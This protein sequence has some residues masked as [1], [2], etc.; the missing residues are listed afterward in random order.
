MHTNELPLRHLL[1]HLDGK[2]TGPKGYWG[3]IGKNLENCEKR[4]IIQFRKIDVSFPEIDLSE[5]STGQQYLYG[6]CNGIS[7]G[8]ISSSLAQREP[9]KMAHSRWLTTAN[10]ILRLYISTENPSYNLKIL[11]E[12]VMKVY[13]PTWFEIKIRPSC[14]HGSS[15]FFG[16]IKKSRFLPEELKKVVD[17]VLQRNG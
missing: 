11:T 9:G 7:K 3:E 5:L 13:A 12:Y 16:I 17:A 1:Q 2:T 10:R 15:H 14:R 8:T 6:I 4:P